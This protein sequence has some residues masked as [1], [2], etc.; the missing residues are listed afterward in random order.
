MGWVGIPMFYPGSKTGKIPKS[1]I[2]GGGGILTFAPDS[3]TAEIP[4][5][6]IS[7]RVGGGGKC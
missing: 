1:H 6:H 3:A 2:F 5:F 7:E 4:Y